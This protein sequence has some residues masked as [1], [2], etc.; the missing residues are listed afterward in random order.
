MRLKLIGRSKRAPTDLHTRDN[1]F[2][3]VDAHPSELLWKPN[4]PSEPISYTGVVIPQPEFFA[5]FIQWKDTVDLDHRM[6][7]LRAIRELA[8]RENSLDLLCVSVTTTKTKGWAVGKMLVEDAVARSEKIVRLTG[9]KRGSLRFDGKVFKE[10]HAVSMALY[11]GAITTLFQ[12]VSREISKAKS[13]EELRRPT[14]QFLLDTVSGDPAAGHGERWNLNLVLF[15]IENTPF[16]SIL[17]N[18]MKKS[19]FERY[20]IETPRAST[21]EGKSFDNTNDIP[22]M[23]AADW[24]AKICNRHQQLKTH[25]GDLDEDDAMIVEI[26]EALVKKKCLLFQPFWTP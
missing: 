16:G 12:I 9:A 14:L 24:F 26:V 18:G 4:E 25:Q 23:L 17:V 13:L 3:A 10:T 6:Q 5:G 8:T 11:A 1:T 19:C 21:S 20:G 15:I 22:I 7:L 2:C